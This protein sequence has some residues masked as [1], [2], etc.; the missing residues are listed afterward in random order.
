MLSVAKKPFM[1][2]VVIVNVIMLKVIMQSVVELTSPRDKF[3]K[4][5]ILS[6]IH[7]LLKR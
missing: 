2:S 6:K 7:K 4:D 5:S 1:L 3:Y